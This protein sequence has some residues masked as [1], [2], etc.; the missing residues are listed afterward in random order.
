MWLSVTRED[1]SEIQQTGGTPPSRMP[2]GMIDR[3][4][5]AENGKSQELSA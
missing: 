2:P 4:S 5:K 1:F 3:P